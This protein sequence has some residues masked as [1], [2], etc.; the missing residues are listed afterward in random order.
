M[1]RSYTNKPSFLILMTILSFNLKAQ[2]YISDGLYIGGGSQFFN[3]T[4]D[5]VNY[6]TD[7]GKGLSLKVGKNLSTEIGL[8]IGLDNADIYNE[9]SDSYEVTHFDIGIEVR[10]IEIYCKPPWPCSVAKPYFRTSHTRFKMVDSESFGETKIKGGG[11]G[12]GF[13]TY[14]FLSNKTAFDVGY[15]GGIIRVNKIIEDNII[16]GSHNL[17]HSG[18]L[19]IGVTLFF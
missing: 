11:V 5:E 17:A 19:K 6:I 10:F 15:I 3:W 2:S 14:L 8:F 18:R 1:I 16:T 9:N 7:N 13:G 12:M 4:F